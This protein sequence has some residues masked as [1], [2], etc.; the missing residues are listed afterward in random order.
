MG[1][2]IKW[3]VK[4]ERWKVWNYIYMSF[5]AE[6]SVVEE[7]PRYLLVVSGVYNVPKSPFAK[8]GFRGNVEVNGCEASLDRLGMT[9]Y[10]NIHASQRPHF[11]V[12]T[13]HLSLYPSPHNYP[14]INRARSAPHFSPFTLYNHAGARARS[15]QNL[16]YD[17]K[18]HSFCQNPA[19]KIF[20][21]MLA[22]RHLFP[23]FVSTLKQNKLTICT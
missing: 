1:R 3:K 2:R 15:E 4:S 20:A 8:G 23:I 22:I 6:R 16:S 5:W 7:S 14:K 21:K 11:S 10:T 12:F 17:I 18:N 9:Y 13:F 19:A